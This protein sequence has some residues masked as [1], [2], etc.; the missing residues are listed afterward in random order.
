M[1]VSIFSH[2]AALESRRDELREL[3]S[4]AVE[5]EGLSKTDL[6]ELRQLARPP[7]VVRDCLEIVYALLHVEKVN[8]EALRLGRRSSRTS[9]GDRI[10][11]EWTSVRTMLARFETFFP[12]ME[13]YD[14]GPLLAAAPLE[15]YLSRT[16]F[17]DGRLTEERVRQSSVACVVLFRWC[18]CNMERARAALELASVEA[19]IAELTAPAAHPEPAEPQEPEL[20][21]AAALE[22]TQAAEKPPDPAQPIEPVDRPRWCC[23]TDRGWEEY[24]P[25]VNELLYAAE[26]D[27][28]QR[29]VN[30]NLGYHSYQVDLEARTQRNMVNGFARPIRPP[31]DSVDLRSLH[32]WWRNSND[33]VLHV[34]GPTVEIEGQAASTLAPSGDGMRWSCCGVD[35]Y[36]G[37]PLV[38]RRVVWL[39]VDSAAL[40]SETDTWVPIA[41]P[42]T[43]HGVSRY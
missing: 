18:F 17:G 2:I 40:R 10:A 24:P 19:Q 6:E 16:Y 3:S 1:A 32:G 31:G 42:S 9:D 29:E 23:K 36:A 15:Q 37:S 22:P 38:N 26:R 28:M 34:T 25:D 33:L 7:Q 21:T 4:T 5:L 41:A 13:N 30:F 35:W 20:P 14:M 43:P 27:G 8:R 12:A 11:I 39:C